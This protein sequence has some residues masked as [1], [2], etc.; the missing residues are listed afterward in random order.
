MT[1]SELKTMLGPEALARIPND[2]YCVGA[3]T[4]LRNNNLPLYAACFRR[5]AD[6]T[7]AAHK[8]ANHFQEAIDL[9]RVT[10]HGTYRFIERQ[11]RPNEP[12]GIR[13]LRRHRA[14]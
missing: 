12:R 10:N 3:P 14:E 1:R 4:R 9:V 13:R 5:R 7:T 8:L 2:G 11:I 6:A